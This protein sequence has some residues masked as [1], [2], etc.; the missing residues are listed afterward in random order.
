MIKQ[1]FKPRVF[2]DK[3]EEPLKKDVITNIG[4]LVRNKRE[5]AGFS[6]SSLSNK[7]RISVSVIEA[8]EKGWQ[9]QLPEHAYLSKILTTLEKELILEQGILNSLLVQTRSKDKSRK[10]NLFTP[11]TI[12]LFSNWQ[13]T[14]VY[15]VLMLASILLINRQQRYLSIKNSQTTRP[16]IS[17]ELIDKLYEVNKIKRDKGKSSI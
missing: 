9:K 7:T 4:K 5:L 15:F 10:D 3:G 2:I 11:G 13:G 14:L 1:W 12:Y 6:R 17:E 8:I 16:I